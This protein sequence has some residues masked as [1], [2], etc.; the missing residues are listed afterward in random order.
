MARSEDNTNANSVLVNP[1]PAALAV[2]AYDNIDAAFG[3]EG[4]DMP[5]VARAARTTPPVFKVR[6]FGED[7]GRGDTFDGTAEQ[8][9]DELSRREWTA[10]TG[11]Q[12]DFMARMANRCRMYSSANIRTD[13]GTAAFV[14]DL[15]VTGYLEVLSVDGIKTAQ[16]FAYDNLLLTE[17]NR[18][19]QSNTTKPETLGDLIDDGMMF[20]QRPAQSTE[21]VR[22][23]N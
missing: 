5:D 10:E 22:P 7:L 4:T 18:T 9:V 6:L 17:Q 20:N 13:R 12:S 23:V 1:S 15:V 21:N 8:I 2:V 19:T 11:S 14:R 16:G 3:E